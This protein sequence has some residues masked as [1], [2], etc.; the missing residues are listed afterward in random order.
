MTRTVFVVASA[1][2]TARVVPE[3]RT[4]SDIDVVAPHA[5]VRTPGEAR[6]IPVPL[7]GMVTPLLAALHGYLVIWGLQVEEVAGSKRISEHVCPLTEKRCDSGA[8]ADVVTHPDSFGGFDG[9]AV[10][11]TMLRVA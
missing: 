9:T 6:I 10:D 4:A 3:G 1:S 7:G 5:V 8:L 11:L 2:S